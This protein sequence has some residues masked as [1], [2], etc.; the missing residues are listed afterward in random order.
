MTR[1]EFDLISPINGHRLETLGTVCTVR[2]KSGSANSPESIYLDLTACE[3]L[4]HNH[5]SLTYN[6]VTNI[7]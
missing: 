3:E 5:C 7:T 2:E 4:W 6:Y 1:S